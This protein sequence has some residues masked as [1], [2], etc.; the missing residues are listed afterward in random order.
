MATASAR[1]STGERRSSRYETPRC[2]H[3]LKVTFVCIVAGYMITAHH[4]RP[5]CLPER[6][7]V[8][9]DDAHTA[10]AGGNKD[11]V[12]AVADDTDLEGYDAQVAGEVDV[13]STGVIR[14]R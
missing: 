9:R 1:P 13:V 6:E 8:R 4:D 12:G 11:Q 10:L 14:E 2:L 7:F 3:L 5:S